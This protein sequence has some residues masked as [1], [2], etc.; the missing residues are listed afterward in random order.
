MFF[1]TPPDIIQQDKGQAIQYLKKNTSILKLFLYCYY[2]TLRI[3]CI[4]IYFFYNYRDFLPIFLIK[5]KNL[6]DD[7]CIKVSKLVT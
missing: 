2:M 7:A 3:N 4:G 5:I 1:K 6:Y